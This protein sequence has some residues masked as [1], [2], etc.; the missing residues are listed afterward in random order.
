MTN[1]VIDF[2]FIVDIIFTFRTSFQDIE[3][4]DEIVNPKE[5][6]IN[7]LHGRFWIDLLAAIPF[8]LVL[9]MFVD[10]SHNRFV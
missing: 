8:E 1:H 9:T 5:I 3:S 10:P 7:Y 2:V 4:G 6:A